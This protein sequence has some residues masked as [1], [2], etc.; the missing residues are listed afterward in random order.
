MWMRCTYDI[1]LIFIAPSFLLEIVA[2]ARVVNIRK[3]SS[4]FR[5][6]NFVAKNWAETLAITIASVRLW[7][8]ILM[9][10]ASSATLYFR[11][12]HSHSAPHLSNHKIPAVASFLLKT[13]HIST[14]PF[15]SSS[16]S[17]HNKP[18]FCKWFY[19]AKRHCWNGERNT[20]H[21]QHEHTAGMAP[22]RSQISF[23]G[24]SKVNYHFLIAFSLNKFEVGTAVGDYLY[25]N[26][27][28]MMLANTNVYKFPY[29]TPAPANP[30][31]LILKVWSSL[32]FERISFGS[33]D[34]RHLDERK[35]KISDGQFGE[36]SL[37]CAE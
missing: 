23:Y 4:F 14:H 28:Y 12:C 32:P 30:Q 16:H 6:L 25:L 27:L 33:G 19:R 10:N 5:R 20:C 7:N 34:R 29:Y 1:P 3:L 35:R 26:K 17:S 2:S 13:R 21:T 15:Q 18:A 36:V 24:F 11:L 22:L 8:S 37:L 9:P 31:G